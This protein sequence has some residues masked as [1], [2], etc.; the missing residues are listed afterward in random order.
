[1][2]DVGGIVSS[3]ASGSMLKR[4]ASYENVSKAES[5]G[6]QARPKSL[7]LNVEVKC[8]LM[9]LRYCTTVVFERV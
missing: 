3:W 7:V 1:M 4:A 2:K 9:A 8:G 5:R 6:V